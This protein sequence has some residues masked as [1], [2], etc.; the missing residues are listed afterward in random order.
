MLVG[1]VLD[2][3]VGRALREDL[4]GGDLTT[5]AVIDTNARAIGRAVACTDL[6]ACGADVF[7]RVF[8]LLDPGLRVERCVE[9]RSFCPAGT[10]LWIVEGST[11]SILMAERT[12]INF[13]QRMC[14]VATLTRRFVQAVPAGC[15]AR[16]AD[17]RKTTPGLRGLERYAVRCG[18][19]HNHRESLGAGVLIKD[20]HI[21][22]AGGVRSAIERAR[23]R[24]PHTVRLEV[25]VESLDDLDVAL[26]AGADIVLLDNLDPADF[27]E[28]VG[29]T[30]GRALVEV[31]G[32]MTLESVA[33]AARAGADVISVGALT[34]SAPAADISLEIESLTGT[35]GR[36]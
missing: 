27:T 15:N 35:S 24:A 19:G 28:A 5:Q 31:S 33:Q 25:E 29:R 14:G 21:A 26:D 20:N 3:I 22:V 8:Y 9:D 13:V 17:T 34:H 2:E 10:K 12:A 16:I 32:G 7:A 18:G 11:R 23:D 4:L 36:Y 1:P 6:V 30:R